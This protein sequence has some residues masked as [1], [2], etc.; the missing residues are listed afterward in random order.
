MKIIVLT[1]EWSCSFSGWIFIYI[2]IV[3]AHSFVRIKFDFLKRDWSNNWMID[4]RVNTMIVI[5]I[6]I[7]DII[8]ISQGV[9]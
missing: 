1:Y 6:H 7:L 3:G 9:N 4:W 2:A 5:T 8:G